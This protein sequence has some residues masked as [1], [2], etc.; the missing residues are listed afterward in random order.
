MFPLPHTWPV[1]FRNRLAN[2]RP[3][4]FWESNT[5]SLKLY[6]HIRPALM[7]RQTKWEKK[8]Q[9]FAAKAITY[10]FAV[11]YRQGYP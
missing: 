4:T 2:H 7:P 5:A 8:F 9:T 11:R 10:R 3:S 1:T 6:A